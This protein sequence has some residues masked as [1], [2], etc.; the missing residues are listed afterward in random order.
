ML[1]VV[2]L[3]VSPGARAFEPLLGWLCSPF[4]AGA[5]TFNEPC[6]PPGMLFKLLNCC[7]AGPPF[8]A[9]CIELLA[10][11]FTEPVFTLPAV[12][13]GLPDKVW[14]VWFGADCSELLAGGGTLPDSLGTPF[15]AGI[16]LLPAAP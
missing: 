9:F 4:A 14:D 16:L 2:G 8:G 5:G 7:V 12:K 10:G 15:I 11:G 1:F 13:F 3:A 6:P